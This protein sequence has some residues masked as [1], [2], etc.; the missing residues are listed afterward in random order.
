VSEISDRVTRMDIDTTS[1]SGTALEANGGAA[2]NADAGER[3]TD[4]GSVDD[5]RSG[6]R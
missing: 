6:G 2:G 5:A 3:A 4:D 1:W